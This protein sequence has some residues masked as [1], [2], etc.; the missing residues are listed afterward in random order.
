M[1]IVTLLEMFQSEDL[2]IK[3]QSTKETVGTTTVKET[4]HQEVI[5]LIITATESPER[6]LVINLGQNQSL[7][8]SSEIIYRDANI[9]RYRTG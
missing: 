8:F 4:Y 7:Q 9:G 3:I 5:V 1:C 6:V 2:V